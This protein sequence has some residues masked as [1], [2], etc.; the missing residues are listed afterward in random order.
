[1]NVCCD[2][3]QWAPIPDHSETSATAAV[4][5]SA[6]DVVPP[7]VVNN[8]TPTLTGAVDTSAAA[9]G[10]CTPL[11]PVR[12]RSNPL[13]VFEWADSRQ[14]WETMMSKEELAGYQRDSAWFSRHAG[15]QPRMRTVLLDWM[16]EV[17]SAASYS[18]VTTRLQLDFDSTLIRRAF[19]ARSTAY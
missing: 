5:R 18:M 8:V 13:P 6:V 14:M 4:D 15:L 1:M 16:M 9:V 12:Q 11:T 2:A 10:V 17:I 19:D 3:M 7:A